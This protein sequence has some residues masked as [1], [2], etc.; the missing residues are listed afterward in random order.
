M[1]GLNKCF[2]VAAIAGLLFAA[3]YFS[4]HPDPCFE[5]VCYRRREIQIS[6]PRTWDMISDGY[7]IV[8]TR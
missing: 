7:T 4:L 8:A 6:T 2:D 1:N 3:L 5:R